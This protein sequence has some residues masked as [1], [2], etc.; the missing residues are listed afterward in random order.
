MRR[1]SYTYLVIL[2]DTNA[3]MERMS[4]LPMLIGPVA[5]ELLRSGTVLAIVEHLHMVQLLLVAGANG[6]HVLAHSWQCRC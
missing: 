6:V 1:P 5:V 2:D 3:K 4:E